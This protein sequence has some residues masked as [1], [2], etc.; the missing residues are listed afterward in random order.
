MHRSLFLFLVVAASLSKAFA[1]GGGSAKVSLRP[2]AFTPSLRFEEAYA[3][4]P[5]APDDKATS[6][7]VEIKSYLNHEFAQVRC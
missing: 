1:Q 5:V 2:L 3:Q 6:V 7:K 4:D